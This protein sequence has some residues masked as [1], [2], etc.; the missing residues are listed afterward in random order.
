MTPLLGF[1]PDADATTPGIITDCT[2]FVPYIN[3]MEAAPTAVTPSSTPALAAACL[4]AAVTTDLSGTRRIYAGTTTNLYELTGGAWVDRTRVGAYTGGADTRWSITQFGNA[5]I[6][7]D[8]SDAMQRA[9]GAAFADIATAPKAEIVF[10]VGA[11]VMALNINDGTDKPDGWACCASYDETTWTPSIATLAATGRL[12]STAGALTAGL[13]LG[14]YAVA[15]KA[16]S[17]YLGRFIGTPSV[18]DWLQVPGGEAGCVG[19]EAVCD[20]GGAH[21]F[22]GDDNIWLFDGTRP[23]PVAD[24]TVRQWFFDNS[25]PLY[26]YR[27]KCVFDRQNN[28]V[29]IFF[30]SNSSS[31]CDSTLV[32]H[33]LTKKW[34]KSNRTIEAVL[35]Y[36]APGTTYDTWSSAGATYDTLP[37][38]AYDSQYW[39]SGGQALSIINTSHQLQL[40]NGGAGASSFT[41]GDAG[42]DESVLLLKQLRLRYAS[43]YAPTSATVQTYSKMNSGD[44][45]AAAASGAVNDGKFD[46]LRAAR[47]HRATFTFSGATRV[48][49][50]DAKMTTQGLR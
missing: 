20:I 42:D 14:E 46:T 2:D 40:V 48:T 47:W 18:W 16:K 17:I 44:G 1:A 6:A 21:F 50:I 12:V 7:A 33:V 25:N 15:Y 39:V 45:F 19:K 38:V 26:R 34:G 23:M 22:V 37:N 43:G 9:T 35:A 28:R 36:V 24:S 29:W 13:R 11:F 49:G 32:Y 41:T 31:T 27:T 30:P 10:S 8:K 4:G 5:T 3:G